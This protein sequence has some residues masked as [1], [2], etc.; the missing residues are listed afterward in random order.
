MVATRTIVSKSGLRDG[1]TR[2]N[3]VNPPTAHAKAS[4]VG[5]AS[6]VTRRPS[7]KTQHNEKYVGGNPND[8]EGDP[9]DQDKDPEGNAPLRENILDEPTPQE[10]N[11]AKKTN[12]IDPGTFDPKKKIVNAPK[13]VRPI[14]PRG[15]VAQND[16]L[17]AQAPNVAKPNFQLSLIFLDGF[18]CLICDYLCND[19]SDFGRVDMGIT[20]VA[21]F[22]ALV[23]RNQASLPK[24]AIVT[25]FSIVKSS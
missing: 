19:F 5:D 2:M 20:D 14:D 12:P 15:R 25:K 16:R 23:R 8:E 9:E 1:D 11:T 21:G 4:V 6:E 24:L 18:L 22:N 10:N 17:G 7:K 13:Q 3:D